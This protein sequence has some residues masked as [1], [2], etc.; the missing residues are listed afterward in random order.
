[1]MINI[2]TYELYAIDYLENNLDKD[3]KAEMQQFLNNHPDI[4]EELEL[5]H[6]PIAMS[7]D[8]NIKFEPKS[9]LKKTEDKIVWLPL[10][11]KYAAVAI[12]LISIGSL[13]F[14]N[15]GISVN[16][17]TTNREID[18][19]EKIINDN[20]NNKLVTQAENSTKETYSNIT[21]SSAKTKQNIKPTIA[22]N[23]TS[24]TKVIDSQKMEITKSIT[25]DQRTIE[26]N[27]P[28]TPNE[29]TPIITPEIIVNKRP[30]V[31]A[32]PM[33]L[34]AGSAARL[35]SG[36]ITDDLNINPP[37]IA[38]N[39]EPKKKKGSWILDALTKKSDGTKIFAFEGV[40]R[41]LTPTRLRDVTVDKTSSDSPLKQF[42]HD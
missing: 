33:N 11:A 6:T 39:I 25:T 5:M 22:I 29:A 13:F 26:P 14:L 15:R 8:Q 36:K 38:I 28:K 31:A 40:K 2:E 17:N 41:A 16:N 18:A 23:N 35:S 32:A 7:L 27:K 37:A 9:S 1:M 30:K 21:K 12:L 42:T 20:T 34:F 24:I 4:K 10:L 3:T 19:S